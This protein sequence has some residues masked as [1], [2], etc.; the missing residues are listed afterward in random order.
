[1]PTAHKITPPLNLVSRHENMCLGGIAVG[2][3]G[4]CVEKASDYPGGNSNEGGR[5]DYNYVGGR[6]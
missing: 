2:Q 4:R 5:G 1:M 6:R 3:E